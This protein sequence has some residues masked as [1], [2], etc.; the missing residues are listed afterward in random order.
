MGTST[1]NFDIRNVPPPHDGHTVGHRMIGFLEDWGIDRK[2]FSLTLDNA[3]Y[4]QIVVNSLK[5]SL[6][7]SLL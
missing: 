1:T 6:A 5:T 4:N 3:S 7:G 2:I